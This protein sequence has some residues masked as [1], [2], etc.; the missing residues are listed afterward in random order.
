MTTFRECGGDL[1]ILSVKL[2]VRAGVNLARRAKREVEIQQ[3]CRGSETQVGAAFED[4][5]FPNFGWNPAGSPLGSAALALNFHLKNPIGGPPVVD[6]RLGQ[7]GD[8][9]VLK[10]LKS[11]LDLAFG[12]RRR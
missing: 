3:G 12:L 8:E 6:F 1:V 2:D 5:I 9:T 4:L 7:P 11:A 10:G